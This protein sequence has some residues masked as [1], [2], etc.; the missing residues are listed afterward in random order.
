[1]YIYILS[2]IIYISY[3]CIYVGQSEEDHNSSCQEYGFS[4]L[5]AASTL[6]RSNMAA[7]GRT[8][9]SRADAVRQPVW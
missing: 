3:N 2:I 1:M 9:V 4:T 7:R 5:H 8:P 6:L